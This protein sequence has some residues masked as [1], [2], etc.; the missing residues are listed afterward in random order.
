M[1]TQKTPEPRLAYED[2]NEQ[3]AFK[4]GWYEGARHQRIALL[5]VLRACDEALVDAPPTVNV[6]YALMRIN[7]ARKAP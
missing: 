7:T 2:P 4:S 6:R 5:D 3:L 1:S